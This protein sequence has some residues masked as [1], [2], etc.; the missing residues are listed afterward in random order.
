MIINVTCWQTVATVN[1]VVNGKNVE[2]MPPD[3]LRE[4]AGLI[5]KKLV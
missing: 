3:L 2:M 4:E 5:E 1:V